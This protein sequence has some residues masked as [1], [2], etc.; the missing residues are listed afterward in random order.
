MSGADVAFVVLVV[1]VGSC[2]QA[3]VGF[4][5]GLIAAPLLSLVDTD[6]VPGPLILAIVPLTLLVAR[7]ERDGLDFWG[8]RWVLV[9]RVPGTIAG[10]VVVATLPERLLVLVLATLVLLAVVLS[11][12]GWQLG[13]SRPTLL[14]AGA[15]SGLM[16]TATSIGGPPVALVYQRRTG[17]ELR[18][19]L[20]GYFVVSSA[21]S[22][23][24]LTAVGE[25]GVH[26]LRLAAV[27]LPGV[28]VGFVLSRAAA[29][30]LDRGYTRAAVLG[31]ATAA[32]IV[33]ILQE[34]L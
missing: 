22:I 8:L 3:S 16:G 34:L 19:T 30:F 20:A 7:R 11:V 1:A 4:G 9:G 17:P 12:G 13:Q 18:A 2:V 10:A 23:V 14:A 6:L 25:F 33:L 15:T 28:L 27:L 24:S 31:G 26:D 5:A 21:L 29:R 32:S